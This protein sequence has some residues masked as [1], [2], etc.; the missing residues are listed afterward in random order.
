MIH[1]SK[2]SFCLFIFFAFVLFIGLSCFSSKSTQ[3]IDTAWTEDWESLY[4]GHNFFGW[5]IKFKGEP[6]NVNYKDTFLPLENS[7]RIQYGDYKSFDEKYAH[8]YY[9]KPFSHFKLRFE[10]KFFGNQV[11]GG[12]VWNVRNSGIMFHSQSAIS[13]GFD[14]HFPVSIE[15]QLLGGLSN[16]DERPTGNMCS[17]GTNVEFNGQLDETHCISSSSETYDGDRWVSAELIVYGDSIIHHIIEGDTVLT[18][19]KPQLDDHF[20]T[21]QKDDWSDFGVYSDSW[22][23]SNGQLLSSGYIALQAESH[24]IEFKGLRL[25]NLKGCMDP[26]ATN[27]KTYFVEAD[28]SLCVYLDK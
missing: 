21:Q 25:L 12:A 8:M 16:G 17:P 20:V 24:P 15:M 26:Q 27:Y 22:K 7:I 13:N 5:D 3:L 4:N 19:S 28:N 11:E 1:V 14:Q 23:K 6:L 2:L 18:Y 10:Y 9:F